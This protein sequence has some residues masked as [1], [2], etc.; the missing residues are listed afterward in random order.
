LLVKLFFNTNFNSNP[1]DILVKEEKNSG[2][3]ERKVGVVREKRVG[4]KGS[5]KEG[6]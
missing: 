3:K 1:F 5:K 4:K 2:K 6:G